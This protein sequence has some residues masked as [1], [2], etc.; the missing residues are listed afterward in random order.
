MAVDEVDNALEE[1]SLRVSTRLERL[2]LWPA[3]LHVMVA[4]RDA[5]VRFGADF[6]PLHHYQPR[7]SR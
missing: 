1:K 2:R 3:C 5:R 7:H 4:F 6:Q